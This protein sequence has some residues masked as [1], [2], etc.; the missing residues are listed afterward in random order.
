MGYKLFKKL[1]LFGVI[2]ALCVVVLGAYVRLSDAGLGCPD[3]PGCYGTLTVPQS[4]AAIKQAQA[5]HPDSPIETAK[6]WKEMAHRYLAGTLG[7]VVLALFVLGWRSRSQLNV[8]PHLL[9]AIL[10]III[11]QALLGMWT[12]TLL[13]KPVI[14]SAHLLGG[15]TTLAVLTWI[16]HRHSHTQ[17]SEQSLAYPLKLMVRSAIF[18]LIA[19]ILLG[20]WTSTNYAALACT[21][22]PT[23][24]G[25]WIPDM[26]FSDAFHLVRELGQS[27]YGGNL[28]LTALTAIQWSHRVGAVITFIYIATLVFL[29]FKVPT[30]RTIA[31]IILALLITQISIGIANLILQLPLVLAVSHNLG[32]ALLVITIVILN[33]KITEHQNEHSKT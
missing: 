4:E 17:Q 18:V 28:S 27:A 6:A 19:Q 24:H 14:V 22:F 10:L 13:L 29:L 15:L 1:S 25:N 30:F 26:D 33:S 16:A 2:L 3:W 20:G 12:V 32:A 23:C 8:T 21:D 5:L 31:L 7:I 11:F 9:T